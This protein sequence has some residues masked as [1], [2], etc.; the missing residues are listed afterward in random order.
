MESKQ[1]PKKSKPN[2]I[3]AKTRIAAKLQGEGDY[4]AARRYD[5]DVRKF[6]RRTDIGRAARAAAPK[7]KRE[8]E[9]MAA[10]EA[11]GRQGEGSRQG[12]FSLT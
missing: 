2:V 8:A 6:V 12:G 5:S 1:T 9:E 7:N 4:E 10:A 11:I 3:L